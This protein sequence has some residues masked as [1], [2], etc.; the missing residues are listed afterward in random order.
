M[1][2]IASPVVLVLVL[3]LDPARLRSHGTGG[4]AWTASRPYR[5]GK[6]S[7]ARGCGYRKGQGPD[8]VVKERAPCGRR[9]LA[10]P[11]HVSGDRALGKMDS[12]LGEFAVDSRRAPQDVRFGHGANEMDDLAID[13]RSARGRMAF[14]V[15]TGP[16]Q[17][18]FTPYEAPAGGLAIHERGGAIR[19][20]ILHMNSTGDTTRCV[21][22]EFVTT[23]A[24]L[25]AIPS[26]LSA[27]LC[28]YSGGAR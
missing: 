18:E 6:L 3:V 5:L 23:H 15:G 7:V 26:A 4:H 9:R 20:A 24:D 10:A 27:G 28:A 22:P 21:A 1:G 13:R 11:G 25:I 14:S 19:A 16:M 12:E 8:V 17:R 2:S